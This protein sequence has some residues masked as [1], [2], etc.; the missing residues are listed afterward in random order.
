M[1]IVKSLNNIINIFPQKTSE[2]YLTGGVYCLNIEEQERILIS[3]LNNKASKKYINS[4]K[5]Y[6]AFYYQNVNKILKS[7]GTG[8]ISN[9]ID[10]KCETI[11]KNIT[12]LFVKIPKLKESTILFRG[13][14]IKNIQDYNTFKNNDLLIEGG[15]VSTTTY[16]PIAYGFANDGN[17]NNTGIS[18]IM[19]I[20]IHNSFEN[21]VIP[22]KNISQ[23]CLEYEV[24]LP[25]KSKFIKL[26]NIFCEN[27][28]F[29]ETVIIP[30]LYVSNYEEEKDYEFL[31]D[32][33]IE[34][35]NIKINQ[36]QQLYNK[37]IEDNK[38]SKILNLSDINLI[39]ES[40][41]ILNHIKKC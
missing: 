12:E 7:L 26:N 22:F 23:N 40:I 28:K 34:M 39:Y 24:L 3:M 21:K 17:F 8:K 30:Y 6:S 41:N 13:I 15:F 31:K 37:M 1:S 9:I 10:K 14:Y 36:T 33:F 32:E 2:L 20:F 35:L 4:L 5:E 18:I 11:I 38:N 27:I 16:F 29:N 19:I 25:S